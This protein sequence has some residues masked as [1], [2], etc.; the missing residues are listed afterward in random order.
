MINS[1]IVIGRL[2]ADPELKY[3]GDNPVCT[4]RLAVDRDYKKEGQ[5]TAD[6]FDVVGWKATA[7]FMSKY[8]VKGQMIAVDGRLQSRTW[9]DKEDKTRTTIEIIAE[10]VSFCGDKAIREAG[11]AKRPQAARG[12]VSEPF[13]PAGGSYYSGDQFGAYGAAPARKPPESDF[14]GMDDNDNVPWNRAY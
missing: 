13:G 3:A 9:K 12:E 7:E 6:F 8:F 2:V 1:V 10:K 11:D 5:P 14:S 4:I